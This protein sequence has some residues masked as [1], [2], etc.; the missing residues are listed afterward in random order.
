VIQNTARFRA[1]PRIAGSCQLLL[2]T[3]VTQ[4][5]DSSIFAHVRNYSLSHH[6]SHLG[7][8][9]ERNRQQCVKRLMHFA[10]DS[11]T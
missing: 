4:T 1:S 3:K 5:D 11:S 9:T 8:R 6:V 7:A 10:K 2:L